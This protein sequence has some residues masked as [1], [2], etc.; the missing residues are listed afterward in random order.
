MGSQLRAARVMGLLSLF[1]SF[2]SNSIYIPGSG[3]QVRFVPREKLSPTLATEGEV[4]GAQ[5]ARPAS[6]SQS[7][8]LWQAFFQRQAVHHMS[9]FSIPY[10][11][12]HFLPSPLGFLRLT[13]PLGGEDS[14][15][16]ACC[17]CSPVPA[18]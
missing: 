13:V 17:L 14:T 7:M 16:W 18:G 12:L 15:V 1:L 8:N 2:C 9:R 3:L 6:L 11:F 4:A 5:G 10:T